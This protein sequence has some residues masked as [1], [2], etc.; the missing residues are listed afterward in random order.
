MEDIAV[1]SAAVVAERTAQ[2]S[3]GLGY[4]DAQR[5]DRIARGGGAGDRRRQTPVA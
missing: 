2:Q 4:G 3:L 5:L 1:S